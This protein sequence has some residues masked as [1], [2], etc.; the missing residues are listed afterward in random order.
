MSNRLFDHNGHP[1]GEEAEKISAEI[2]ARG[3]AM[4]EINKIVREKEFYK[5]IILA[6]IAK[7]QTLTGGSV[8]DMCVLILPEE[9]LNF[10]ADVKIDSDPETKTV[11]L[12]ITP[13]QENK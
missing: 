5:R 1:V 11:K 7:T 9:S 12:T 3:N 13:K 6:I 8:D 10:Q 4:A 2:V